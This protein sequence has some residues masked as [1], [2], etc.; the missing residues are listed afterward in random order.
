RN[1]TGKIPAMSICDSISRPPLKMRLY[2]LAPS[3][4]WF[5]VGGLTLVNGLRGAEALIAVQT[6]FSSYTIP[7]GATRVVV[8]AWGGGGGGQGADERY[9][10]GGAG[11]F[12]S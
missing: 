12:A 1:L 6:N 5:F 8:K 10:A 4:C 3:A 2:Q 7:S 9:G 11:G